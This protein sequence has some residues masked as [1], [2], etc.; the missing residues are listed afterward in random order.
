MDFKTKYIDELIFFREEARLKKD[1]KLSDDIRDYLDK[2]HVFIFDNREEQVVYNRSH[3]T[4]QDLVN[5]LKK[6]QR[7]QKLFD[8]WLYS[9]QNSIKQKA[10]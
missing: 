4:R 1:W 5:Q 7:A 10:C 2:K 9:I 8:T 6:E 3:G